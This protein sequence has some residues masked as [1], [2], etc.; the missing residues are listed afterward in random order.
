V[1][2]L[3]RVEEYRTLAETARAKAGNCRNELR[4]SYQQIARDYEALAET[5]LLI[6]ESH[7]I[8]DKIKLD[9]PDSN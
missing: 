7:R 1:D 4:S 9:P 3:K 8:I 6:A 5:V 2:R